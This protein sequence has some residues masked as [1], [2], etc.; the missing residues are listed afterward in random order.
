MKVAMA[1]IANGKVA[2]YV[3]LGNEKPIL[4]HRITFEWFDLN[5]KS[6]AVNVFR[7]NQYIEENLEILVASMP[8]WNPGNVSGVRATANYEVIDGTAQSDK[9][10]LS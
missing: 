9:L 7:P 10:V 3:G 5:G 2:A 6:V 1:K 8:I 4:L